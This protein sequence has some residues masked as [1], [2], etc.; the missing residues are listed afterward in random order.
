MVFGRKSL[1]N[2]YHFTKK[3]DVAVALAGPKERAWG[4]LRIVNQTLTTFYARLGVPGGERGYS[5]ST[6]G[7]SSPG[8]VWYINGLLAP[9]LYVKRCV[10]PIS[11]ISLY[12]NAFLRVVV[13]RTCSVLKAAIIRPLLGHTIRCISP[14]T[15]Q[16]D[17]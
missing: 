14:T 12:N 1:N 13:D 2:C 15:L 4:P 10:E 3:S 16:E 11:L 8:L 5:G 7:K 17:S 6:T 9:V